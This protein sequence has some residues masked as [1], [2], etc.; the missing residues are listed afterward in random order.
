M[1]NKLFLKLFFIFTIIITCILFFLSFQGY[2]KDRLVI[3]SQERIKQSKNEKSE[4]VF[5]G[6]SSLEYGIE[7]KY[8]SEL[9]SKTTSNLALTAG[10]HNISATFNMIRNIIKNNKEVKYIVIMQN[11][12]IWQYNF[13]EG[14]YCTTLDYLT[15]NEVIEYKFLDKFG[16]FKY[17]YM[18]P[19]SIKKSLKKAKEKNNGIEATY[20]NGLLDINKELT[21]DKYIDYKKINFLKQKEF[22][23][24]DDYLKNKNVKVF[25]VQGTLHHEIYL[26]YSQII[27]KQHEILKTFKNI[28]FIEEYLYP[29]N[30]NMGNAENHVD[31]SYKR[32]STEFFYLMLKDYIK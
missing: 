28:T 11:P 2:S 12:S 29:A 15:N 27:E 3:K 24:I 21:D 9:I 13:S 4:I 18:N 8:F 6:D 25:Y 19:V 7:E 26:K 32:K 30:E 22:K 1:S 5:V 16:C 14:G 10:A 23:M 17:K 20:K 31:I